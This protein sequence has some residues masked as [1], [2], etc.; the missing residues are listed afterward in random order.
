MTRRFVTLLGLLVL[1]A[2]AIVAWRDIDGVRPSPA[3]ESGPAPLAAASGRTVASGKIATRPVLPSGEIAPGSVAISGR[4]VDIL[5]PHQP[6]AGVEVVFR[7]DGGDASTT[8]ESDGHYAIRLPAGLYRAFVRDDSVLSVGRREPM[9]LPWRPPDDTAH[10]PDEALM[11]AV[12]AVRDTDGVNLSVVRSGLL[13]GQVVDRNGRPIDGAVVHAATSGLRPVIASDIAVSSATGSFELRLPPGVFDIAANHPRFA[14]VAPGTPT[15]Y[16]VRPGERVQVTVTLQAGCT[17]TGRVVTRDGQRAGDGALERQWGTGEL[18]F[19]PVGRIEA[20]GAFSWATTEEVDLTL[21]AWPW[22]SPPS[23][24]RRFSCRDGARFDDVVFQLTD[25]RPDLEGVLVDHSGRPLPYSFLDLRP[26]DPGGVAQQERTDAA[27]RWQ[28][29][30]VPPGRYRV[31]AEAERRGVASVV[32]VSPRDGVRIELG[33]T[34]RLEGTT[35]NLTSGTFELALERCGDGAEA[36]LLPQSRRLVTVIGG[37]F[38]LDDLPACELSYQAMW[39]GHAIGQHVAIPAG[40]VAR[41]EVD[42]GEPRNKMV[43][44]VVKDGAG[45]P[46]AGA[47]VTVALPGDQGASGAVARSDGNGAYTVQAFSGARLTA[48]L[49]GK[50]GHGTVGGA[51]VDA[52]RVD[53]IIDEADSGDAPTT[54]DH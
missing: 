49:R 6:V 8:T 29:Y 25:R 34:G 13:T 21:R 14:G 41:V 46:L 52:E 20:D 33:G 22:K 26:L 31:L 30:S 17:I 43:R 16:A 42:L 10:V 47:M 35:P 7:G 32:I 24:T 18:E 50:V 1:I 27:G 38:A 2:L 3:S 4:V 11:A 48:S 40:G 15:R 23:Q 45:R 54:D 44:G 53:L 5:A 12:L 39:R 36:I 19:A 37:R 9:R 28:V 51:D